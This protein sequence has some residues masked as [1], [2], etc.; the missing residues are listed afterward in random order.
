MRRS[1][2]I[3]LLRENEY[4]PLDL[5]RYKSLQLLLE[6]LEQLLPNNPTQSPLILSKRQSPVQGVDQNVIL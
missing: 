6:R 2:E 4:S 1:S 3:V 5:P